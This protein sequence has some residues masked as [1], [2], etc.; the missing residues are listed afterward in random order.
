MNKAEIIQLLE[1]PTKDRRPF[2]YQIR[3]EAAVADIIAALHKSTNPFTRHLLC[4]VLNLR[5]R[6]EFF[7]RKSTE[8]LQAIPALTEALTDPDEQVRDAARDALD[9]LAYMTM[10]QKPTQEIEQLIAQ[11]TS[12]EVDEREAAATALSDLVDEHTL[13]P[14]LAI[15]QHEQGEVRYAAALTL[16]YMGES[17]DTDWFVRGHRE[18]VQG[19]LIQALQDTESS[20]R[21]ATAQALGHWGDQR[22]VEPLLSLIQ[23]EDAEVHRQVVE[24]IGYPKDE[25]TLEPLL[26]AFFTDADAKVRAY[27]AQGLG[28]FDDRRTVSSLIHDLQDEQPA[29]RRNA[30]D[31]CIEIPFIPL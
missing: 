2:V 1:K 16:T 25:R 8:T 4:Y 26:H 22:S 31:L 28:Y 24:T 10:P 7:E 6:V 27:A 30:A 11:L 14:L 5:A 21:A 18:Q 20:V 12:K 19:P 23:D 29:L 9:H 3:N 17:R 15:L 13:A